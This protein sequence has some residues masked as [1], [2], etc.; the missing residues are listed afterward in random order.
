MARRSDS[1]R[2]EDTMSQTQTSSILT[3]SNYHWINLEG[4]YHYGN[5]KIQ[6][7]DQRGQRMAL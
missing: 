4:H 6:N 2:T 7:A 5:V 1:L 3:Y